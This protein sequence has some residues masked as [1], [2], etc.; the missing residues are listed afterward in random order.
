[1]EKHGFS[2]VKES[3][4][5]VYT[6]DLFEYSRTGE[7]V[8]ARAMWNSDSEANV[9]TAKMIDQKNEY[10][11]NITFYVKDEKAFL[12]LASDRPE[13]EL[14][15]MEASNSYADHAKRIQKALNADEIISPSDVKMVLLDRVGWF[16]YIHNDDYNVF[17]NVGMILR[18]D[19]QNQD[20][21]TVCVDA[22]L[23]CDA[24]KEI[25]DEQVA[26]Y[27][28]YLKEKQAW[29]E[30]HPGEEWTATGNTTD[31]SITCL[32]SETDNVLDISSYFGIDFL[33]DQNTPIGVEN[34]PVLLINNTN[35]NNNTL[36]LE[37]IQD[38]QPIWPV[39]V[40]IACVSL[41]AIACWFLCLQQLKKSKT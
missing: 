3:I 4:T 38:Q 22:M 17:V 13:N 5:P 39:A 36:H 31:Q 20:P 8:V 25:A 14:Y 19:L 24:V 15:W 41:F 21:G 33:L 1:M 16:F 34:N 35:N 10:A 2:I 12:L 7:M 30:S 11:G 32:C 23:D 37:E 18:E 6:V 28:E 27:N 9:Y 40:T 26:R 29:E